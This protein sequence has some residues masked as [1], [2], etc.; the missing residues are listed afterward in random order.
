MFKFVQHVIKLFDLFCMYTVPA[1]LIIDCIEEKKIKHSLE[2]IRKKNN[3]I[4]L[5]VI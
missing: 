3:T 5:K 2:T 4:L 1:Y